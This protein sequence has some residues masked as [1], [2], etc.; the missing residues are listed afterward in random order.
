MAL[1][2]ARSGE[3][4]EIDIAA[5]RGGPFHAVTLVRDERLEVMRWVLPAGREVPGHLGYGPATLQCLDGVVALR[6]ADRQRML[7]GGAL[8]YLAAG[9]R[10]ALT[11]LSDAVLLVTMVLVPRAAGEGGA[12]PH[13][14]R[15]R[16]AGGHAAASGRSGPD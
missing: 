8:V 7:G 15:D 9:E 5:P 2:H 13:G 14:E 10:H 16:G 12:G 4:I 3:P 1:A 11:A 6:L